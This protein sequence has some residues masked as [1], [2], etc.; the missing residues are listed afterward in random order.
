[1]GARAT[2]ISGGYRVSG[3]KTFI[4]NGIN[5]DLV[6][7]AV[8]T[9]P[10]KRHRGVSLLVIE[11]GMDGFVR[12]RNLEKVGMHSQDTAELFFDDVL[13]PQENLLGEQGAGFSYLMA[14]LAQERLSIAVGA[15]AG[16]QAAP[17]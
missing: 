13:V 9:D 5:S 15:V 12:G 11:R 16:A 10:H 4:T 14:N 1:M 17:H 6:I 8:K 7:T 3:S 2:A